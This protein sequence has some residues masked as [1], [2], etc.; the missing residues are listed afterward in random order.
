MIIVAEHQIFKQQYS[1][2]FVALH[3]T[4]LGHISYSNMYFKQYILEYTQFKFY[5]YTTEY[6]SVMHV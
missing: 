1:I 5:H 4:E 3:F 6:M 2:Y